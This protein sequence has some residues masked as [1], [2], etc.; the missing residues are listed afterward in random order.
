MSENSSLIPYT[1]A[2]PIPDYFKLSGWF[3][4]NPAGHKNRAFIAWAFSFTRCCEHY[5]EINGKRIL[6]SPFEFLFTHELCALQCGLTR[7]ESRSRIDAAILEGVLCKVIDKCSSKY[8]V[9]RWVEANFKS[10]EQKKGQQSSETKQEKRATKDQKGPPKGPPK[11]PHS[12]NNVKEAPNNDYV[13]D[14]VF[15]TEIIEEQ[16][17]PAKRYKLTKEQQNTYAWL[18]SKEI[19]TS[20]GTLTYWAKF[21]PFDKIQDAWHEAFKNSQGNL[22]GYMNSLLR[23][24]VK[25][26]TANDRKN[27][28][29][30]LEFKTNTPWHGLEIEKYYVTACDARGHKKEIKMASAPIDFY[31]ELVEMHNWYLETN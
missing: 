24:N 3:T 10:Y 23:N 21:Y 19:N 26:P 30:A 1:Y 22:G 11:G 27:R 29:V 4:E 9:Y 12:L 17:K 13:K 25:C 18:I 31:A 6:L 16:A 8:S 14:N 7:K 28:D 20:Q 15:R 5:E 2:T